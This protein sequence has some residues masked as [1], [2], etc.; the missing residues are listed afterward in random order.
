MRTTLD[1]DD[2]VLAAVKERARREK[3]SAGAILSEVARTGL[4]SAGLQAER[5]GEASFYGFTPLTHRGRAVT[6]T[7]VDILREDDPE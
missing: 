7:L 4:T 1:I 3:R 6:N 5:G 2:D